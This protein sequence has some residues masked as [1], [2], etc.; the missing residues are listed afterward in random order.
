MKQVQ[1]IN[2]E[3]KTFQEKMMDREKALSSGFGICQFL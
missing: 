2:K 1:I 3:D